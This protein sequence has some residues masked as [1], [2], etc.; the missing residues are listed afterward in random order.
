MKWIFIFLIPGLAFSE[1]FGIFTW[2]AGVSNRG[3][4]SLISNI[5][6]IDVLIP[7]N[8]AI[9][10]DLSTH[11]YNH[12]TRIMQSSG[13][14]TFIAFSSGG[15]NENW[16]G[17]QVAMCYSTNFGNTWSSPMQV[18]PS[19]STWSNNYDLDYARIALPRTFLTYS[20]TNY[21]ISGVDE[22]TA[23]AG[24]YI[25]GLCLIA[26][27][28]NDNGTIGPLFRI[29]TNSYSA[30][31][32]KASISYDAT[33]GPPLYAMTGGT[34]PWGIGTWGG[35]NDGAA[36]PWNSFY[37]DATSE[38]LVDEPNVFQADDSGTNLY[39][40][41]RADAGSTANTHVSY[42]MT[43]TNS[44]RTWSGIVMPTTIPNGPSE[45]F[46]MRLS[47]GR[48]AFL[49]NP[50]NSVSDARDPLYF[51]ITAPNSTNINEVY[52]IRQGLS[53][54]PTYAG[55][56][57]YGGASYV[58]AAQVGNSIFVAYSIHKES[59]GFSKFPIPGMIT[60]SFGSI[61]CSNL[62]IQ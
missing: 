2:P 28:L 60:S 40:I 41:W 3:P 20:G 24:Y 54:T 58:S 52:S 44:G 10:N 61:V 4:Y 15:S 19:Q 29:T 46:G 30:I 45:T 1:T 34:W 26:C 5:T 59:I 32:G 33:L 7:T 62:L 13:G 43:S 49:G 16:A 17:T 25:H 56:S 18:V 11:S 51:A 35:G 47:N 57:K 53:S 48:F 36:T 8:E 42:Q 39:S 9:E 37:W 50:E 27:A 31:D 21:L 38:I 12:H 22:N 6:N 23:H 55:F 14:T